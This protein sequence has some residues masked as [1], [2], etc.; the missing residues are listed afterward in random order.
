MSEENKLSAKK[1]N[2]EHEQI[3]NKIAHMVEA[4]NKE[5][6]EEEDQEIDFTDLTDVSGGWEVSYKTASS[7]LDAESDF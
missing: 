3:K 2:P 5:D 7:S 6:Q 1:V 4:E